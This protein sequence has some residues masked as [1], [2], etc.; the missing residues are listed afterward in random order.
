MST[1]LAQQRYSRD[2]QTGRVRI[3]R[4]YHVDTEDEIESAPDA[5]AMGYL[6]TGELEASN[7]DAEDVTQG[8]QVD[9]TYE[10]LS[11]GYPDGVE[12]A[13]WSFRPGFEKEPIEKH[14]HIA[15]LIDNYGGQED[16]ETHRVTFARTLSRETSQQTIGA[17]GQWG[18]SYE[19]T[20]GTE[21]R[22]NPL[23]GLDE[24]GWLSM[25]GVAVCKFVA[26]DAS[27]LGGIGELIEALPGNAPDF[28]INDERNWIKAP[29]QIDEIPQGPEATDRLFDVELQFLLSPKGGWPPAVYQFIEV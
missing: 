13:V 8:F 14:Q 28:G 22:P 6:F 17:A 19:T 21:E 2:P 27:H 3:V 5:T 9:A 10:G 25:S 23:Y 11:L 29:P 26:R 20:A 1:R 15:F 16:P 4:S 7:W 18:F 24:S 12:S